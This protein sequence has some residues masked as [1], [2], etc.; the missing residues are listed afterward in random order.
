MRAVVPTCVDGGC[1]DR[2]RKLDGWD[3]RWRPEDGNAVGSEETRPFV[4]RDLALAAMIAVGAVAPRSGIIF[5][6]TA[7]L[8]R[9]ARMIGPVSRSGRGSGAAD[10]EH[11][12]DEE[13]REQGKGHCPMKSVGQI[14][15][16]EG[17]ERT[18]HSQTYT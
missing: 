6:G 5:V 13:K 7:A 3:G 18:N 15:E 14:H 17:I 4:G 11:A 8:V 1:E 16:V 10:A 2:A 9:A 12:R